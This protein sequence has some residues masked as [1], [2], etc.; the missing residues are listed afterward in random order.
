MIFCDPENGFVSFEDIDFVRFPP[1][2]SKRNGNPGKYKGRRKKRTARIFDVIKP[3]TVPGARAWRSL[4]EQHCAQFR[5]KPGFASWSRSKV[6][7]GMDRAQAEKAWKKAKREA[8][9]LLPLV[10]EHWRKTQNNERR[11]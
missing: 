9:Q 5:N 1:V 3:D 10:L 6:P 4:R 11:K 2:I 7:D 8:L